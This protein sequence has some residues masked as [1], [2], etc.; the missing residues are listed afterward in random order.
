MSDF[1]PAV[2]LQGAIRTALGASADLAALVGT[3]IYDAVPPKPQFP[4]V[5][6]GQH[7]EIDD[8]APIEGGSYDGVD[9]ALTLHAWSQAIGQVEAEKIAYAVRRALNNVSLTLPDHRLLNLSF[10][11]SNFFL[12]QDGLTTRAVIIFDA[13]TEPLS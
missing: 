3:R 4:Y 7:Q 12:D 13:S 5:D 6:I 11:S 1:G 2:Q 9:H 8:G 10:G